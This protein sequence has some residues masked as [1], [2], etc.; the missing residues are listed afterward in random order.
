MLN[1]LTFDIED[2]YLSYH[3]SQIP[4]P[5]W[6]KLES[7]TEKNTEIIIEFLQ[8]H[9]LKATFFF[10]GYEV[11]KNP[12]L[13]KKVY[14]SGHEIGFHSFWH[15]PPEFQNK[16]KF[17][18]EIKYGLQTMADIIGEQIKFYRAPSFS[19]NE[20]CLWILEILASCGIKVSSS[21]ISGIK[22]KNKIVPAYPFLWSNNIIEFPLQKHR[23]LA[24]NFKYSGSG[25]LRILPE[26]VINKI[27]RKNEYNL[28]YFHPR[29]FD[30]GI[31]TT[32]LLP[33]Y[34]N[35]MNRLGNSSTRVKLQNLIKEFHF[36]SLGEACS[37]IK[38]D[39]IKL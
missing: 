32:S 15:M 20:K 8:E 7:R 31:P 39:I 1:I 27:L 38:N 9:Q 13:L 36:I 25:Y 16:K 2:W 6:N 3:S 30:I 24:F 12:N 22:I 10:L 4:I 19:L 33:W 21:S 11:T 35:R 5:E 28:F 23:I 26:F 29:D 17:E 14:K 18:N 37:K 34:R